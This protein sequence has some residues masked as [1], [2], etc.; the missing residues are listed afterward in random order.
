MYSCSS[1]TAQSMPRGVVGMRPACDAFAHRWRTLTGRPHVMRVQLRNHKL[2][3][4]EPVPRPSGSG[5]SRHG[6][7]RRLGERCAARFHRRG[8]AAGRRRAAARADPEADRTGPDLDLGRRRRRGVR[9]MDRCAARR[10][11]HRSGVYAAACARARLRHGARRRL[12]A[13]VARPGRQNAI[14][15]HRSRQSHFEFDLRE[16][17]LSSAVGPVPLRLRRRNDA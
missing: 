13:G 10:G 12:V 5:A 9:R 11:A 16:D 6:V 8:P 4:V 7:R 14:P 2:T 3:R 1:G 15:D 17:R